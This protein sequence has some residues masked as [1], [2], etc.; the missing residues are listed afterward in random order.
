[1]TD[2][3]KKELRDGFN[4]LCDNL[5]NITIKSFEMVE[6]DMPAELTE[7]QKMQIFSNVFSASLETQKKLLDA[8][9]SDV[10]NKLQDKEFMAKVIK[11]VKNG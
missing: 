6:K 1:M 8:T 4:R 11:E 7:T 5:Y 2:S 3:M 10:Q 9:T